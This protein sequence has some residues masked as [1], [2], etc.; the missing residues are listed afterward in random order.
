V[1]GFSDMVE[2]ELPEELKQQVLPRA[3]LEKPA[4]TTGYPEVAVTGMGVSCEAIAGN[5]R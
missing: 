2:N 1:T 3:E 4:E 5:P